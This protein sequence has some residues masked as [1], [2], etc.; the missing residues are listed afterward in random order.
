[1]SVNICDDHSV[2]YLLFVQGACGGLNVVICLATAF[3]FIK[4]RSEDNDKQSL[5]LKLGA[6]IA[7]VFSSA[8]PFLYIAGY[9]MF[10]EC[11]ENTIGA[12]YYILCGMLFYMCQ[13]SL[14]LVI[15]SLRLINTFSGTQYAMGKRFQLWVAFVVSGILTFIVTIFS[16][17]IVN[18]EDGETRDQIIETALIISVFLGLF[19]VANGIILLVIFLRKLTM[20]IGNASAANNNNN[21]NQLQ[22]SSATAT[23]G[24]ATK[25]SRGKNA[26][27]R[28]AVS[29]NDSD[30]DEDDDNVI[31]I[32]SDDTI[33][34]RNRDRNRNEDSMISDMTKY[35]ILVCVAMTSTTFVA[36][37]PIVVVVNDVDIIYFSTIIS[38]DSFVNT[39]CLILQFKICKEFYFCF[40]NCL[41]KKC[42]QRTISNINKYVSKSN[43]ENGDQQQQSILPDNDIQTK[44]DIEMQSANALRV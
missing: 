35:T 5:R 39:V 28:E 36:V 17:I 18:F 33:A 8:V 13:A 19:D 29:N 31:N 7:T 26:G 10:I 20:V 14:I 9:S 40:C 21:N 27:G 15:F 44:A 22:A 23:V 2:D 11:T 42:M 12:T 6:W 1:M 4:T 24:T 37:F 30:G 16:A 41:H 25:K 38:I 34:N 3:G 43:P 32:S